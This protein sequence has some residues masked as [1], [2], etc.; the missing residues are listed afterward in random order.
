M[1]LTIN[2]AI[3]VKRYD[4]SAMITMNNAE[5]KLDMLIIH[6]YISEDSFLLL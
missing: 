2:K 3:L 1:L 6:I 4:S 5:S